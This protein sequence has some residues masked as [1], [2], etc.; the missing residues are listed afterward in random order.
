MSQGGLR[1]RTR[2][3]AAGLVEVLVHEGTDG[4]RL[5]CDVAD[6]ATELRLRFRELA[7]EQRRFVHRMVACRHWANTGATCWRPGHWFAQPKARLPRPAQGVRRRSA[8]REGARVWSG[9]DPRRAFPLDS[10][11]PFAALESRIGQHWQFSEETM[12][13]HR[14]CVEPCASGQVAPIQR[15]GCRERRSRATPDQG[16]P[17]T[18]FRTTHTR[19]AF[20]T[21]AMH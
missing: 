1:V 7:P 20:R 16:R 8:K 19:H 13:A 15:A 18:S 4:M 14:S 12:R 10:T 3:P 17:V 11:T 6:Q 2:R 21:S 9:H 5:P